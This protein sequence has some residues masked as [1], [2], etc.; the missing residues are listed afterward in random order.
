MRQWVGLAA[1]TRPWPRGPVESTVASWWH[2]Q[3]LYVLPIQISTVV[4]ERL[5]LDLSKVA[6]FAAPDL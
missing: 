3:R 4:Q 2:C 6:L 1:I 5:Y